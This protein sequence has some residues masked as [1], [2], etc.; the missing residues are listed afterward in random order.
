MQGEKR[1]GLIFRR[2]TEKKQMT[3]K[4]VM[5][6]CNVS[7]ETARK[8]L[9]RLQEMGICKRIH[10]G[11]VLLQTEE[12]SIWRSRYL[13]ED[14]IE[15]TSLDAIAQKAASLVVPG[16]QIYMDVGKTM[17]Q[18]AQY[19]KGIPNLTVIT[20][21]PTGMVELT[22]SKVNL[23]FLGGEMA[24]KRQGFIV[25]HPENLKEYEPDMAFISCAG[26]D[27]NEGIVMEYDDDGFSRA[28]L[29]KYSKKVVLVL[30]SEKIN[31]KAMMNACPLSYVDI[32]VVDS[33]IKKQD[34]ELLSGYGI[35]VVVA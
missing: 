14:Q 27:L 21:N 17:A 9:E 18:M 20:P 19:I 13:A 34:K 25:K 10:G 23:V 16:S 24:R 1:L 30:N 3:T 12:V 35:K 5:E 31:R 7:R 11:A 4:E 26:L 22:G 6:L 33:G 28:T 32:V 29:R 15:R 2:L 8:E